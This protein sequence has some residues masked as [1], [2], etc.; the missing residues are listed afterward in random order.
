MTGR[1]IGPYQV[2]EQLGAGGMG[3]VCRARDTRLGRDVAVEVLPAAYASDADR[4][5][6]F[7]E[8]ARAASVNLPNNI[9]RDMNDILALQ[10][11]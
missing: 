7:Q 6:R 9:L 1:Q 11:A 5:R 4:L 10:S 2:L 8:E 3:E